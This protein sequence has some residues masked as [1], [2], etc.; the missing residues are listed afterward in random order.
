MKCILSVELGART[1][2]KVSSALNWTVISLRF[3]LKA[4]LLL[5]TTYGR[6]LTGPGLLTV[7][8]A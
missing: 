7:V 6:G 5:A 8:D 4:A 3:L 1:L 2:E